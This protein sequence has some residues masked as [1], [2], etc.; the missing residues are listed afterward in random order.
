MEFYNKISKSY[1]ELYGK[2]QENKLRIIKNNIKLKGLTLDIGSGTGISKKF[3]NT[4]G[5][6]PSFN[7]LKKGDIC[8][9]AEYL[10]FKNKGFDNVICLTSIHH[11][12]L[13]KSIKE[14]K[15]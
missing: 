12:N 8:G 1:D 11:F 2:E 10:P 5:I 9:K 3:F 7:L 4:I 13:K 6:D 14:M 15:I